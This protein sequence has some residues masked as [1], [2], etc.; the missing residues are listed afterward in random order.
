MSKNKT[1]RQTNEINKKCHPECKKN[2]Q[3]CPKLLE[4]NDTN[5]FSDKLSLGFRAIYSIIAWGLLGMSIPIGNSYF[6]SI[7]L[8]IIPL[9][10]DY[11][12]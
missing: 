9:C 12:K 3:I 5:I 1:K 6:I 7:L 11:I 2:D 10:M 4:G 8:F